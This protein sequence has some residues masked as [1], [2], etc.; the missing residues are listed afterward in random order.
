MRRRILVAALA[1]LAALAAPPA[2]FPAAVSAGADEPTVGLG[3]PGASRIV[4]TYVQVD[5][6]R[7]D[8]FVLSAGTANVLAVRTE[9]G[10]VVVDTG[11]R[12][13]AMAL[14]EA[15]TGLDRSPVALAI[16]THFH[17]DHAGG[18]A[19]Y[20]GQKVPVLASRRT[21]SLQKSRRSRLE[22][23]VPLEIAR[24]EDYEAALPE[25]EGRDR[26]VAFYDFLSQWWREARQE[27]MR[28]SLAVAPANETFQE[29]TART[30]GHIPVEV[31]T[32]GPAHTA[33]DAVVF[34]PAQKLVAVGDL[35]ARGSAPWVDQFMGDGSIEGLLAA[36]DSILARLPEN[37]TTWVV[38]PGH[39]RPARRAELAANRKA[40]GEV[41]A[42]ARGAFDA[43]RARELASR[44]CVDVGFPGSQ[45]GMVTWLFY[46]EWGHRPLPRPGSGTGAV[47]KRGSSAP[48]F[49]NH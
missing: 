48:R 7:R 42:C 30:V 23:G 14:R 36:Q 5:T 4:P 37:D 32:F 16:N 38:V 28:D 29:R 17:D 9:Q 46:E 34:F 1:V 6:L 39:G 35:F 20:L 21:Q 31:V 18:N 8:A 49:A 22:R 25:G 44:D 19:L 47:G 13:E 15:M 3:A 40:L 10:W 24:F 41:R 12:L 27:A 43:G 26:L 33:G 11:T 2:A 45:G